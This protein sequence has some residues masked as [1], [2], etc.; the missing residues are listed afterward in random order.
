MLSCE[1]LAHPVANVT[2]I[3][4][5][6]DI[7]ADRYVVNTVL[8]SGTK[9][10]LVSTLTIRSVTVKDSGWYTC[11]FWNYRGS[12]EDSIELQIVDGTSTF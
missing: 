3:N 8:V 4:N 10:R 1:S 12:I 9:A 6:M 7:S 11:R 2:W 5:N